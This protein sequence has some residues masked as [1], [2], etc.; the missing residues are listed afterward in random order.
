MN[1]YQNNYSV[2]KTRRRTSS[3]DSLSFISSDRIK[4]NKCLGMEKYDGQIDKMNYK[5]A[6]LLEL[7]DMFIILIMII[8]YIYIY[9][10]TLNCTL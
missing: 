6:Q 8:L 7:I 2:Q 9:T 3:Q 4:I 5:E 1:N 10:D